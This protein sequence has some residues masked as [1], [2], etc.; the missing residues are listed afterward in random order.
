[1]PFR[2]PVDRAEDGEAGERH[3]KRP[4]FLS[5]DAFLDEPAHAALDAVAQRDVA[6]AL[7]RGQLADVGE[8]RAAVLAG[9]DDVDVPAQEFAQSLLG[10]RAARRDLLECREAH[11]RAAHVAM[12]DELL[13]VLEVVVEVALDEP[14][15]LCDLRHAQRAVATLAQHGRRA[16]H[17]LVAPALRALADLANTLEP[18]H[19]A[20]SSL[21]LE[22][23]S[24]LAGRWACNVSGSASCASRSRRRRLHSRR[25][26]RTRC[27]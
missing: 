6:P 18:R 11:F 24:T 8:E 25:F 16:A 20:A 5:S 2:H 19:N 4:E 14:D 23:K 17:D 10:A 27:A 9:D 26:R 21:T 3:W 1:M 7:R 15:V 22:S 13:P 12:E